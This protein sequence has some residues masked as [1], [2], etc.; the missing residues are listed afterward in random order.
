M[1]ADTTKASYTLDLIPGTDIVLFR[2]IGPITFDDRLHNAERMASY[3][4]KKGVNRLLIDGTGQDS[5]TDIVDSYEF[6]SK[7][8]EEMSGLTIA[9]VHRPDDESLKFIETVAFNRGAQTR[10][11]ESVDEARAWLES[12]GD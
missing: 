9:V 3:C 10:A 11:F 4:R 7:V 12:T 6:G 2:W 8:P 5:E 1:N